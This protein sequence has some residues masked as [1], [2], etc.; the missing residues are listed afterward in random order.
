MT[1]EKY[2]KDIVKGIQC[3]KKRGKDI[4]KQLLSE[5]K[6]RMAAGEKLEDIMESMGNVKEIAA[7]FNET[8]TIVMN[9]SHTMKKLMMAILPLVAII[10]AM[11][12]IAVLIL[13]KQS[14]LAKS[15]IFN[16]DEV[17]AA[18]VQTIDLLDANDYEALQK[19]ARDDMKNVL[20]EDVMKPVKDKMMDDWG[21]RTSMGNIYAVEITQKKDH[22][23]TCQVSAAYENINVTYTISFDENMHVAGLYVK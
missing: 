18:V 19:N 20:T 9:K 1:A 15:E 6:E 7:S 3:D 22:F 17:N 8:P 23:A 14:D 16:V 4:Q 5:V 12:V 11:V 21:E 10:V 2:V 13:P